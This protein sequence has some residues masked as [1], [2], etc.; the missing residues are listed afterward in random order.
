M[1]VK[2][3]SSA[4]EHLIRKVRLELIDLS[5]IVPAYNEEKRISLTLKK[6]CDFLNRKELEEIKRSYEEGHNKE[7]RLD[8]KEQF[9]FELFLPTEYTVSLKK[10][11]LFISDFH[12]FNEKEY[13]LKYIT[14]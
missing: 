1:G 3:T 9:G 10:E 2:F 5:I 8:I 7:A 11:G 13:L 4:Y 6:T 12:S 14:V